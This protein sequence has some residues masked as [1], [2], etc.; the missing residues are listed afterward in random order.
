MQCIKFLTLLEETPMSAR[1]KLLDALMI[2]KYSCYYY[3]FFQKLGSFFCT[4]VKSH[5][6][7]KK[8]PKKYQFLLNSHNYCSTTSRTTNYY[9]NRDSMINYYLFVIVYRFSMI[10]KKMIGSNLYINSKP[11]HLILIK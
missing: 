1:K 7:N 2:S 4:K 3:Y 8:Y 11:D 6:E 10:R 9:T 5:V